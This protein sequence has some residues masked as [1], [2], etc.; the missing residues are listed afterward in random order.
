[1]VKQ[2]AVISVTMRDEKARIKAH[3]IA[4]R[5]SGVVSAS[6]EQEKGLIEVVGEFDVVVLTIEL[7]K[8]LGHADILTVADVVEKKEEKKE[9]KKKEKKKEDEQPKPQNM[10]VTYDPSCF[11][12]PPPYYYACPVDNYEYAAG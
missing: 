7:R 1:M 10:M 2:K 12:P 11:R 5:Q 4:V 8:K 6:A 3:M 9:E